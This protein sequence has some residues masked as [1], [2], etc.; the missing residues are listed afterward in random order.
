MKIKIRYISLLLILLNLLSFKSNSQTIPQGISYQGVARSS[1]N[2]II[3]N[4]AINIKLGIYSPNVNGTLEWEEIDNVTTNQLGLF[5]FII[6]QG[7]STGNGTLSSFSL[8]NWGVASHFI[9]IAMDPTGTSSSF[10]NID[11]MQFWSVPYAMYSG[12]SAQSNQPIR[13]D[14]LMDVDTL[15]VVPGYVLKYNGSLWVPA[16]DN[17]SD[18]AQYAYNAN[19]VIHADTSHFALNALSAVD[20]VLFSHTTDTALFSTHSTNSINSTNSNYCD[21]AV[22][23]LNSINA[24]NLTGNAGTN[25]ATNFIGTIDNADFVIK[26][27]N[28]EQMRVTS[29]GRVGIGITSPSASLHIVG[30]DGLLSEGTFGTGVAPP[31]GAGTRMVWYPKKAAFRVG[32]VTS[33]SWDDINIGNYSFASGY[34]TIASGAYSTVFGQTSQTVGANSFAAG[35]NSWA[36][37]A[38]SVA[39]GQGC[40]AKSNYS[41]AISRNATASD[42]G[43]VAIGYHNTASGKYSLSFGSYTVSSGDYSTV[44]GWYANSNKHKGSFVYADYSNTNGTDTTKST[45][46]NQFMVRAA[47]GIIFYSNSTLTAGVSLPAGGG[48]WASVSDRNKKEHFKKEDALKILAKLKEMDI[49]SWNYKTQSSSIRHIGPMAQDFYSAFHFGESDTTITTIDADGVSLL[50]IQALAQ[51]TD[52]LKKKADEIERLKATIENMQKKNILLES[53]IESMEK[54]IDKKYKT[55]SFAPAN[56]TE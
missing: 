26:T 17:N 23:A 40:W 45:S 34:N 5:Y 11:T 46:D 41:V 55:L 39:L 36:Y 14:Q 27:N 2:N 33:T 52:E 47:G 16:P 48:A 19:H 35:Q 43:A 56:K 7:T 32:G 51:K 29:A 15:G 53:R 54:L 12:A 3:S 13:L 6:G 42:T 44:M 1:S 37:G 31:S 21:T 9:K 25:P 22:Y 20:T 38:S 18:T 28:T 50:A 8:I 24:W 30:N 4:Q 49:S 10:V